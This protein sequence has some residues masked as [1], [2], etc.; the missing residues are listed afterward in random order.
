[1]DIKEQLLRDHR[2][3]HRWFRELSDGKILYNADKSFKTK[4]DVENRHS[5]LVG[6]MFKNDV[7]HFLVDE[8]DNSLD[9]SVKKGCVVKDL[10]KLPREHIV[11]RNFA[12]VRD[13]VLTFR[14]GIHNDK[15]LVDI[16][17][18]SE[19]IQ[20]ILK[21]EVSSVEFSTSEAK[22]KIPIYDLILRRRM[23][24]FPK[25]QEE[26]VKLWIGNCQDKPEGFMGLSNLIGSK[27]DIL[28]DYNSEKI[29][30]YD[31]SVAVLVFNQFLTQ[32]YSPSRLM[33]EAHRV[34][35]DGGTLIV[36]DIAI[37]D[38]QSLAH[39]SNN[40][41]ISKNFF[42][43][44]TIPELLG[45]RPK[46][47]LV[48]IEEN[49]FDEEF[50]NMTFLR[51][52]LKTDKER[53]FKFAKS[54]S[55]EYIISNMEILEKDEKFNT[56]KVGMKLN[57]KIV[58]VGLSYP[59]K[60]DLQVGDKT[61]TFISGLIK[62]NDKITAQQIVLL[63]KIDKNQDVDSI[64]QALE[65]KDEVLSFKV[66][67]QDKESEELRLVYGVVAEPGAEDSDGHWSTAEDIMEDAHNYLA[68]RQYVKLSHFLP[69]NSE[70]VE[71]YISPVDWEAPD[72][73][74][75]LKDSWVMTIRVK[76]DDIWDK[77]KDGTIVGFSK[78]GIAYKY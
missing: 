72:G 70:V 48:S 57:E 52:T 20:R 10:L 50:P 39:P 11:V 23:K 28:I 33:Q 43:F 8:L 5:F 26:A 36:E 2:L 40:S 76:E 29:P 58:A 60:L 16:S 46:F 54:E 53:E 15:I 68:K 34:L 45:S 3:Y 13:D 31:D 14:G 12:S 65:T 49:S 51:V 73:Q 59:T 64:E 66:L 78:G 42:A 22:R 75:I 4:K 30:F 17:H 41:Q 63:N 38:E 47:D 19:M 1:M 37:K 74:K 55:D 24:T 21:N 69:T 18:G 62:D 7:E 27:V 67:K 6:E 77:V 61:S 9:E 25:Q 56:Y 71:S 32:T 44:W 35:Q